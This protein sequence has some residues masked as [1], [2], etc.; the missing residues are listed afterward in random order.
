MERRDFIKGAALVVL[1]GVAGSNS[2]CAET[3][4]IDVL[5]IDDLH[6]DN[7]FL[8]TILT[9]AGLYHWDDLRTPVNLVS[10]P[11][12][13]APTWTDFKGSQVLAFANQA[14][15]GN[16]EK[17]YFALQMPHD[18]AEGTDIVPHVHWTP[19]DAVG[20]NVRW[21]LTYSW[22]NDNTQFPA[23]STIYTVG[24]A[25]VTIDQHLKTRFETVSGAGKKISSMLLC[26]LQR[27]SSNVLDTYGNAAYLLEFD[28]HYQKDDI[29]SKTELVK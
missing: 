4:A 5:Y 23:E 15:E 6:V 19:A 21:L 1:A 22:A 26:K 13:K 12:E 18:Y 27:N 28:I 10:V 24:A 3:E 29:G 14:V 25:G 2:S 20:G 17:V 16:E 9:P 11:S 8:E 7:V